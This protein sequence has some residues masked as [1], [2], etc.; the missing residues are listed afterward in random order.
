[1]KVLLIDQIAKVNYKY[2][3]PLANGLTVHG[4][5]VDLVIDQKQEQENCLCRLEQ[6]FNTSEKNIGKIKKLMNYISSYK[7]ICRMLEGELYDVIHTEWY[8]FS[9]IDYIFIKKIKNKYKVRYVATVHDILPFNQMKYDMFFHKRLYA[10]ADSIILQAPGNLKRFESLFPES[11][12][13]TKMIP[14]GHML[15]YAQP[16]E[17]H[18]AREKLSIPDDRLVF[19]FF[20]QIKKVKGVDVLLRAVIQ[21]QKTHP[22]LYF[23][24]AGSVWKADFSECEKL[25]KENHLDGYVKADIRYIPDDEVKDYYSASD[26][27][28]LPY[29]D[30]YQ[31]GVI[32]LSYAYRKPVVASALEAFTQFVKE[33]KTGFLAEPGN[34]EDLALAILRAAEAKECLPEIGQAGYDLVKKELSWDDITEQIVNKCYNQCF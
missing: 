30:V 4:I 3:F 26:V 25:I 31:S 16:I 29:T 9:P 15:D 22:E 17:Q 7:Y 27:S 34:A 11:K 21:L 33:G 20:G 2:T 23:I 10:L 5:D 32:Q 6:L 14:H 24:I 18:K 1:M 19:L 13:K 12:S 28:V 8:T